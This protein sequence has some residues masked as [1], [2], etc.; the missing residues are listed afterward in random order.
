[1][2][3]KAVEQTGPMPRDEPPLDDEDNPQSALP[4]E[5]QELQRPF[6]AARLEVEALRAMYRPE[7]PSANEE[8]EEKDEEDADPLAVDPDPSDTNE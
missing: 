7:P 3:R 1:M 4:G 5:S 6:A 2:A 8:E